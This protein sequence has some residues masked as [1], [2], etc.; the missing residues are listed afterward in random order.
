MNVCWWKM[1][2]A[3][4]ERFGLLL[5]QHWMDR[6]KLAVEKIVERVGFLGILICASVSN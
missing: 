5:F 6:A 4:S 2:F 1:D 3:M